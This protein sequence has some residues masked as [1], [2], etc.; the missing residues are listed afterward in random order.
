MG[1]YDDCY[2]NDDY[3]SMTSREKQSYFK[4]FEKDLKKEGCIWGTF[5]DVGG[6]I[7]KEWAIKHHYKINISYKTITVKEE[8]LLDVATRIL[9]ENNEES[10]DRQDGTTEDSESK[11]RE[12]PRSVFKSTGWIPSHSNKNS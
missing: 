7:L 3:H 12:A 6:W 4:K 5:D 1:H 9:G 11:S 10:N 2:S 8:D